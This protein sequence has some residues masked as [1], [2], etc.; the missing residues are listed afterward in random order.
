[1]VDEKPQKLTYT[2]G[3]H[4]PVQEL[5][6]DDTSTIA[7]P[8]S[9]RLSELDSIR[10]V[11]EL[12]SVETN[13]ERWASMRDT[14]MASQTLPDVVE[15]EAEQPVKSVED[16]TLSV[17]PG[18]APQQTSENIKDAHERVDEIPE[19]RTLRNTTHDDH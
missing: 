7:G 8:T 10:P 14:Q 6:G 15:V 3:H 4:A 19:E 18:T 11:S 16:V 1:M 9:D 5:Y 12:S 17:R 13:R 2:S